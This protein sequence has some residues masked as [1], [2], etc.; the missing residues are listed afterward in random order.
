[1]AEGSEGGGELGQIQ[2]WE[3]GNGS[4]FEFDA[5]L[6]EGGFLGLQVGETG[7]EGL[8]MAALGNGGSDVLDLAAEFT[9]LAAE[10]FCLTTILFE[11]TGLFVND[12]LAG[13]LEGV[14]AEDVAGEGVEDGVLESQTG[15]AALEAVAVAVCT[16]A[17]I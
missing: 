7:E 8:G 3:G 13:G 9:E 15:D 17:E 1:M 6:K 16:G 2:G 14:G 4:G 12:E 11:R 5:A 10:G